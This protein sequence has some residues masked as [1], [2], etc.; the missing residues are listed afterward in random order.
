M[1]GANYSESVSNLLKIGLPESDK[2]INY[3]AEYELG[4]DDISD[5][6]QLATD[7]ELST[8]E[9]SDDPAVYGPVHACRALAQLGATEAAEPLSGNFG[10]WYG[11]YEGDDLPRVYAQL[12]ATTIPVLAQYI[13]THTDENSTNY[14]DEPVFALGEIARVHP[15]T[16]EEVVK[17]LVTQ[18]ELYLAND[19]ILNSSLIGEL[20]DLEAKSSLPLIES[21]FAADRIDLIHIDL[22][23][24]HYKFRLID[25]TEFAKRD[26][27]NRERKAQ[28]I[29]KRESNH[30]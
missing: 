18:L 9:V 28:L 7:E 15:E 24:V 6:I 26:E 22:D 20:A 5:L 11:E 1:P 2:W 12:G 16:Y 25:L 29:L 21:V 23:Y 4:Q 3:P 17:T 8:E 10:R 30:S 27:I 13:K 14:L 19:P